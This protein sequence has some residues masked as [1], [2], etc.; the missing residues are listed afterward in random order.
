[1]HI[2]AKGGC[3][4]K[5]PSRKSVGGWLMQLV[6]VV[7]VAGETSLK[8]TRNGLELVDRCPLWEACNKELIGL[9]KVLQHREWALVGGLQGFAVDVL[10]H[11]AMGGQVK[12]RCWEEGCRCTVMRGQGDG[13]GPCRQAPEQL[14]K[15]QW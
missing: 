3:Y 9:W 6:W 12:L 10:S 14:P 4:G 2:R 11:V 8:L 13:Q 15:K 7:V 5:P 1:M